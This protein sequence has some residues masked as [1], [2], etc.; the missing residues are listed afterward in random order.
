M[1]HWP[2]ENDR[3]IELRS[4]GRARLLVIDS[5]IEAP[6]SGDVLEDWIRRPAS[7][8]DLRVRIAGLERRI[9]LSGADRPV[10]DDCVLRFG[11]NWVAIPPVEMRIT[12][13]LVERL[14]TV[15]G[16]EILTRAGWPDGSSNRN[17][18]DV[19]VMRLR[20]RIDEIGLA[21]RTVRGRGYL[22][23]TMS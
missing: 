14:D 9:E 8:R 12:R 6:V 7:I 21:I 23:E 18:L 2:V 11:G 5:D 13:A 16:R 19:Q 1:I 10:I 3:L 4:A 20:R 22:L 17:A 15:V